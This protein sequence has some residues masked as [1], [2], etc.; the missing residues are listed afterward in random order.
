ME[1]DPRGGRIRL[2]TQ[3]GDV[4]TLRFCYRVGDLQLEG[5]R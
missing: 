1:M 2:R 3:G 4:D 5:G